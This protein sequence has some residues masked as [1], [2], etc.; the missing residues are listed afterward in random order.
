MNPRRRARNSES[1]ELLTI[2]FTDMH[3]SVRLTQSLGDAGGQELVRAHNAIARRWL[4]EYGGHEVKQTGDG[5][6]ATFGSASRAVECA[7]AIMRSVDERNSSTEGEPLAIRIGMNAGEPLREERDIFGTAVQIAARLRDAAG[8]GEILAAGVVCELAAGKALPFRD[9][10]ELLLR[11]ITVPV[12]VSVVDWPGAALAH[13]GVISR[14]GRL[15]LWIAIAAI[16]ATSVGLVLGV[17]AVTGAFGEGRQADGGTYRRLLTHH[18]STITAREISGRCLESDLVVTGDGSG[19]VSGDITGEER[20]TSFIA[21][22]PLEGRCGTVKSRASATVTDANGNR[23]SYDSETVS[24]S[25]MSGLG[26][27]G[28][29]ASSEIDRAAVII[30]GGSGSYTGVSGRGVCTSHT[31]V[32]NSTPGGQTSLGRSVADCEYSI[33]PAGAAAPLDVQAVGAVANTPW[34]FGPAAAFPTTIR[35]VVLYRNPR[36]GALTD[37]VLH[38]HVPETVAVVAEVEGQPRQ[39]SSDL[40]WPLPDIAGGTG[41]R[42]EVTLR[43]NSADQESVTL[44]PE[45]LARDVP[46]PARSEPIE[47][48]LG[49]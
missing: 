39:S 8:P 38:L 36:D 20:I 25:R 4:R 47:I 9:R 6:L 48:A 26:A 23:L 29:G 28:K 1:P 24:N 2:L 46:E 5:I 33:A 49:P 21:T 27:E 34:V 18:E 3:G 43:V 13:A 15:R 12:R 45:L 40:E 17:L 19:S 7:M 42:F 32:A 11:G 35:L 31:F 37:V 22:L 10:G 30:T 41:G 16:G 14:P 44:V